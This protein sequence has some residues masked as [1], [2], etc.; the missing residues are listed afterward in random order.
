MTEQKAKQ[1]LV[2]GNE[3]LAIGAVHGGCECFF[4]YPITPQSEVPEILAELMPKYGRVFLQ[5][6]S[7]IASINM[8]YGA[9]GCGKRAMTSSSSPGI[10]LMM[11]GVSY[12]AGAELPCVI[13]NVMRG[14]PGLGN[15]A[16]SQSDYFQAVKGGGHGDYRCITIA[17]WNVQEM[18]EY[19]GLA[20]NLAEKYRCPTYVLAD[21]V[22]GSML[23]PATIPDEPPTVTPSDKPWATV[24]RGTRNKHNVINSLYLDPHELSDLNDKLQ[25]VYAKISENERRWSTRFTEDAEHLIIA[26]GI[27]AR[28]ALS[29]ITAARKDGVKLGLFRPISL[30]PFPSPELKAQMEKVKSSFVFE[31]SA[32][33]MVEDVRLAA[34]ANHKIGFFGKMGGV[35]PTPKELKM[36]I[37]K[38]LER[39]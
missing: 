11:E 1:R 37:Y 12:L 17:P 27:S 20:F 3:A 15:I 9:A 23:E 2:K 6:E 34:P 39:A 22:L 26:Y 16:P 5:A 14:G 35:V 8:V 38:F 7:E 28:L 24:G 30:W 18:Y 25:G 36:E 29:A 21:A 13:I 31:L 10:S 19:P 33:Q 32:G 4:G